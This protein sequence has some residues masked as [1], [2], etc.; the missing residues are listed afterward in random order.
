MTAAARESSARARGVA[1]WGPLIALWF[2]WGTTY[3]GSSIVGDT[4]PPVMGNGSRLLIAGLLLATFLTARQGRGVLR[5]SREQLRSVAVM[6]TM[7]LAVGIGTTSLAVRVIPSGIAALLV[8]VNSLFVVLLRMRSGDRPTR[9]TGIGVTIGLGGLALMLLPGGT[10]VRAG[11]EFDA[12]LWSAVMLLATFSWSYFSFR[13]AGYALPANSLVTATYEL[14][15][16]GVVLTFVGLGLGERWD[17]ASVSG[18]SWAGWTWLVIASL[19]GYLSFTALLGRAPLSLVMTYGYVNPVV[20]VVL[21]ALIAGERLTLDVGI[22]LTVVLGGVI[23][24]VS[25]ERVGVRREP[26][27]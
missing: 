19:I 26:S 15:I 14:M 23:L 8:S 18:R 3:L 27:G 13:S 25:G 6:G 2:V 17:L 11:G 22:G 16:A 21:G 1:L 20:A 9:L 4:M 7:L 12:V 24:V 10:D 5:V